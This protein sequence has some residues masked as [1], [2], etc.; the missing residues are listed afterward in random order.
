MGETRLQRK[1]A[2]P[3]C[4][5]GEKEGLVFY[6]E[7]HTAVLLHT[8]FIMLETERPIL[9]IT[10][11]LELNGYPEFLEVGLHTSGPTLSQDEVIGG[12]ANL[13]AAALQ[14]QTSRAVMHEPLGVRLQHR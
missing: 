7:V 11:G 4:G 10:R 1:R 6:N 5:T 12:C 13:I 14:R 3:S 9:A 2:S 8:G